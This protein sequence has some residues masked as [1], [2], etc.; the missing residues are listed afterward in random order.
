MFNDARLMN[1]PGFVQ[2]VGINTAWTYE[3]E[4]V[5]ELKYPV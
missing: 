4:Y 3:T 5:S 1:K 2:Y